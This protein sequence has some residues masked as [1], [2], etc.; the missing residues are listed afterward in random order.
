MILMRE[1][2]RRLINN[3]L[4]RSNFICMADT[5]LQKAK[6]SP[7]YFRQLAKILKDIICAEVLALEIFF[8]CILSI[9]S[10]CV[11]LNFT[12]GTQYGS[13]ERR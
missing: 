2:K 12:K 10:T 13:K 1:E 4:P 9:Q 5:V 6:V 7:I 3:F 11:G 8:C